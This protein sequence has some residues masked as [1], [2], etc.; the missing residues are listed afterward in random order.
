MKRGAIVIAGAPGEFTTKPRPYLIVQTNA[1]IAA[2][3]TI[4]LCPL[5]SQLTGSD[6]IRIAIEP[7]AENGLQLRS[8]VAVD[9]IVTMRKSR[10]DKVLGMASV[11]VMHRVDAALKRWLAL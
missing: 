11:D 8:E 2:S 3:A 5:T 6:L 10:I 9:L 4:S 1:A 7:D